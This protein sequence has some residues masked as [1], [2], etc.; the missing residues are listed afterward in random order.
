MAV[1]TCL[2]NNAV[3]IVYASNCQNVAYRYK[4]K[5]DPTR[6][7]AFHLNRLACYFITTNFSVFVKEP[8]LIRI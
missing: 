3:Y 2:P 7:Q 8:D 4:K 1:L 5:P 6:D